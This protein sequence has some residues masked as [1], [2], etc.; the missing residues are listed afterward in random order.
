MKLKYYLKGL[1][2]GILFAAVILSISF[3]VYNRESK[4]KTRDDIIAAAMEEGMVWPEETTPEETTPEETTPKETTPE[5]TT[6]EE[7]IPEETTLE[8]TT[9]EETTPR[10]TTTQDM[11]STSE[12][13]AKKKFDL[14]AS[15]IYKGTDKSTI[16]ILRGMNSYHVSEILEKAGVLADSNEREVFNNFL[17]RNGYSSFIL[18][19]VF[20]IPAGATHEQIASI[21]CNLK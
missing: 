1:G 15:I 5:E 14:D 4:K 13:E 6:P 17:V 10:E 21:I 19:G 8:E 2:T 11:I 7:T 20:D 9:P 16:Q 18:V 12:T 3:A